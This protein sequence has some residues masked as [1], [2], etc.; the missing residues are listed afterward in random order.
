M[1]KIDAMFYLAG[2][3]SLE[4]LISNPEFFKNRLFGI[5]MWLSILFSQISHRYGLTHRQVQEFGPRV[6]VF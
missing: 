5:F 6:N 2:D 3:Q 1:T 4:H